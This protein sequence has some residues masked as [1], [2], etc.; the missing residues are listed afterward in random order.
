MEYLGGV[1]LRDWIETHDRIVGP[2]ILSIASQLADA[3]DYAH[4]R[5]I[6]HR[7]IKPG[8]VLFESDPQGRIALCDFGI[9]SIMGA[10]GYAIT[11]AGGD[12]TGSPGYLAPELIQGNAATAKSDI[13]S[14]GIVL[15]EMIAK[16][17]P[18]E[19][20]REVWAIIREKVT[21][22]APDIRKFR[23][24]VEDAIVTRLGHTLSRTPSH[25]P[26]T[27]RAVLA[28]IEDA[29]RRL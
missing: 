12:I 27:A 25:R 20:V 7:D 6:I 19:N 28:G 24:D 11:A 16:K 29:I 22:P 8:N 2:D 1:T 4:G 18:F 26:E 13:Y 17:L 15:Y 23:P 3:I 10:F 14:F 9:A 5:G 21:N